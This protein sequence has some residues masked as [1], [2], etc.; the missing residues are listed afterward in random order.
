MKVLQVNIICINSIRDNILENFNHKKTI[1]P[2][3]AR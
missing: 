2:S 3:K 1:A